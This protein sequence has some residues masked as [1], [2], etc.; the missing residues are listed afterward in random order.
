MRSQIYTGEIHIFRKHPDFE[1]RIHLSRRGKQRITQRLIT[2][3]AGEITV[4]YKDKFH[5]KMGQPEYNKFMFVDLVEFI[6]QLES[7]LSDLAGKN[8]S[9]LSE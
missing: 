4:H 9:D 3:L 5:N 8:L 2:Y 1:A 6:Y 7:M